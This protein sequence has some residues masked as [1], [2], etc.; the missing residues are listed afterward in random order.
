MKR[1]NFFISAELRAQANRKAE[2][3]GISFSELV[4][5]ALEAYL[6][7]SQPEDPLFDFDQVYRHATPSDLSQTFKGVI[8][9]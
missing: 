9:S 5:L 3:L 8:E 2:E 7:G 1:T 6:S 4:R